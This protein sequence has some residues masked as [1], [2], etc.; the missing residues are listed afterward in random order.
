MR[1]QVFLEI[2]I[3]RCEIHQFDNLENKHKGL[4]LSGGYYYSLE[5]TLFLFL[6]LVLSL[7]HVSMH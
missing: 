7:S 2:L 6:F 5:I 1:Q 3:T 4:V